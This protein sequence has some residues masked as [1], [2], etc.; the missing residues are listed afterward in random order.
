MQ[1]VAAVTIIICIVALAPKVLVKGLDHLLLITAVRNTILHNTK[2]PM[3]A[4][5][6]AAA[7][8]NAGS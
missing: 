7:M 5:S 1:P 8:V 6:K 4:V 3:Q 2:L